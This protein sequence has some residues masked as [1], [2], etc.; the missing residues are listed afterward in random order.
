[1][2][3]VFLSKHPFFH[4]TESQLH[5]SRDVSEDSSLIKICWHGMPGF[6][7]YICWDS[8]VKSW[9]GSKILYPSSPAI[10]S[11]QI[12][13]HM[14]LRL[15]SAAPTLVLQIGYIAYRD[16]QSSVN[17][18]R[19]LIFPPMP[20]SRSTLIARH[21]WIVVDINHSSTRRLMRVTF[22]SG[23]ERIIRY[24]HSCSQ[25]LLRWLR[26]SSFVSLRLNLRR[27]ARIGKTTPRACSM[28]P[29]SVISWGRHASCYSIPDLVVFVVKITPNLLR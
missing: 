22:T 15:S 2:T 8:P 5:V 18:S 17:I 3:Q 23:H 11:K 25:S 6:L 1:M 7:E 27:L 14:R 26:R 21:P 28:S 12:T 29:T 10:R 4:Y 20:S 16:L 13:Q 24:V 19:F 9:I